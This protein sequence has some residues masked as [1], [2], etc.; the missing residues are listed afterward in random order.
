MEFMTDMVIDD[1]DGIH[2]ILK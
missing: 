2:I 1:K